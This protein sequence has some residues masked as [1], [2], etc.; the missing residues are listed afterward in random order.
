MNAV[1]ERYVIDIF[2]E[3]SFVKSRVKEIVWKSARI[4]SGNEW[5]FLHLK[6]GDRR[7]VF[8][9]ESGCRS[10]ESPQENHEKQG[11]SETRERESPVWE[12]L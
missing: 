9:G 12:L 8:V 6:P 2:Y 1:S 3:G 11:L 10:G 5:E 4:L 7:Q